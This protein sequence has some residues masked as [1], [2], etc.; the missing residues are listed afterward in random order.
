MALEFVEF[1]PERLAEG[2]IYIS[3]PFTTAIH[4]CCCGCGKEV[5][6]PI[7]PEHWRLIFDGETISLDPSI[8]NRSFPCQSHYW[9]RESKVR[10][11]PRRTHENSVVG[12]MDY[13]HVAEQASHAA[14]RGKIPSF[15][16]TV[17]RARRCVERLLRRHAK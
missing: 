1:I 13:S 3:I 17:S 6:T 16:Y 12:R 7:R 15:R 2:V 10:W 5:V 9:I 8:G 4:Q 14:L 11:V